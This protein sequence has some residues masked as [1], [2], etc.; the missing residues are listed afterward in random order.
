MDLYFSSI[1]FVYR[2][3][4]KDR[5]F[6]FVTDLVTNTDRALNSSITVSLNTMKDA[7]QRGTIYAVEILRELYKAFLIYY[8]R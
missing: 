4:V 5:K 2:L 6:N 8:P 1:S 3:K 7:N